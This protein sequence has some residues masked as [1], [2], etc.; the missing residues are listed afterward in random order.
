ML[1]AEHPALEIRSVDGF[2]GRYVFDSEGFDTELVGLLE[3]NLSFTERKRPLFC[4]WFAP[5]PTARWAL[6]L[7]FA[8]SMWPAPE[9]GGTF[10]WSRIP[11]PPVNLLVALS[12][13]SRESERS[14]QP[15]S[16]PKRWTA[17]QCQTWRV[18]KLLQS[19]P[20]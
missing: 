18:A 11:V 3:K 7:T 2:Q 5:I 8:G 16:T 4:P 20:R 1:S 9:R 13:T 19:N 14:D 15:I 17:S 12:N 10:A 6:W